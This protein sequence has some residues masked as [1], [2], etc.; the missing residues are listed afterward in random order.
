M[1]PKPL[2]IVSN[3]TVTRLPMHLRGQFR[4]VMCRP[5]EACILPSTL[6]MA[7]RGQQLWSCGF[8]ETACTVHLADGRASETITQSGRIK[9]VRTS[10]RK[11]DHE[12]TLIGDPHPSSGAE[13]SPCDVILAHVSSSR[14]CQV[15]R[16]ARAFTVKMVLGQR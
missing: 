7:D 16:T 10:L 2:R 15:M 5:H 8:H 11:L 9:R 4:K 3:M 12:E 14:S 6:V 13:P 1:C